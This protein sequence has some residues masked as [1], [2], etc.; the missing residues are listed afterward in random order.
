MAG[1]KRILTTT[2]IGNTGL[3]L[4][5]LFGKKTSN[6]K[7]CKDIS[8]RHVSDNG[9][10][11]S[12]FSIASS[13]LCSLVSL[14]AATPFAPQETVESSVAVPQQP[15]NAVQNMVKYGF[16]SMDNLRSYEDFMLSYDRRT[17]VPNWVLEHLT[18]EKVTVN[19]GV[20][21]SK[22]QFVEDQSVHAYHRA[23]NKD[24]VGSGYDRGHMAAAANHRQSANAMKQT[25]TL[26]NIAPQVGQG[27]NR[28]AWNNL[29]KYVR[30]LARKNKNVY[31]CTGPL[32]LP[33][34]EPN[35]KL[36]VKYEV[37]G[38]NHVAVPTH[39]FKVLVIE[40][41][42]GQLE[43]QSYIMPNQALPPEVKLHHYLA[44]L[45]MIERAAGLNFFQNIP[46]ETFRKV[47]SPIAVK[48]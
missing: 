42:S 18:P 22:M 47:N 13:S 34:Y 8:H 26:S 12:P 25:F 30:A 11:G 39:F 48:S 3:Y 7:E 24:Y 27:F 15:M 40:N 46:K 32:F 43:L 28:D 23:T 16:P 44:P 45:D 6:E 5:F 31:V 4:G 20:E 10:L 36:Y 29:E 38:Q 1:F 35:G 37:I 9:F 19:E 21:R 41:N 33:Q 2:A 14:R 17:R